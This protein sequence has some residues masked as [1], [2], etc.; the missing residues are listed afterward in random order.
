MILLPDPRSCRRSSPG[1]GRQ[2]T[3]AGDE[4]AAARPRRCGPRACR[5][6]APRPGSS[7][8]GCWPRRRC[9]RCSCDGPP[10]KPSDRSSASSC[11]AP[12]W[13][14]RLPARPCRAAGRRRPAGALEGVL[15]SCSAGRC[16]RPTCS[17][18]TLARRRVRPGRWRCRPR[19]CCSPSSLAI[20]GRPVAC[21]ASL[22]R[23]SAASPSPRL[24]Q[25]RRPPVRR[26]EP[27]RLQSATS[28]WR[29]PTVPVALWRGG[30]RAA[31]PT[32]AAGPPRAPCAGHRRALL[33]DGTSAGRWSVPPLVGWRW[34][35]ARGGLVR[36]GVRAGPAGPAAHRRHGGRRRARRAR[37][38][39]GRA[40][41]VPP[42]RT[43]SGCS[44]CWTARRSASSRPTPTGVVAT[45]TSAGA[46]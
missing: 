4:R 34:S 22:H 23:C 15:S 26:R 13:A 24:R 14:A 40:R 6:S 16:S 3:E 46:S 31:A 36:P 38:R 29:P 21:R 35:G 30:R 7:P 43:A 41:T 33:R 9:R 39:A 37:R 42:S 5:A 25:P 45:S 20:V 8:S 28:R 2:S 17:T 1:T 12:C 44:T 11:S 27:A 10:T 32:G 18:S 19:W